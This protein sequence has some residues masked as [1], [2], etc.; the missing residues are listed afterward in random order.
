MKKAQ[1]GS[2]FSWASVAEIL[3]LQ[4]EEIEGKEEKEL[5]IKGERLRQIATGQISRGN[6]SGT[7]DENID[8]LVRFL[9]HPEI[10]FLS[11]EDLIEP[12][13]PYQ[14]AFQLMEF[15]KHDEHSDLAL[16]TRHLEGI[17]R[18]VVCSGGEISDI[19]LEIIISR[20]GHFVH[21]IEMADIFAH[22]EIKDPADWSPGERKR[23][24]DR[25][26]ESRGWGIL[27]PEDTLTGF[28]KR[29]SFNTY[30]GNHYSSTIASIPEFGA[31]V[32]EHLALLAYDEAYGQEYEKENR[33][34][35][36]EEIGQKVLSNNL[37]HFVRIP[38]DYPPLLGS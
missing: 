32:I 38:P 23:Y 15:L 22:A 11:L 33:Q 34:Q 19:R 31:G 30:R 10:R 2:S 13:L 4:M 37:R 14:F 5:R 1:F 36:F 27:T 28:M 3:H 25:Y 26:T 7:T 9:T 24:F 21:F 29:K 12:E 20:D 18:A 17:Y 6:P 16:P 8:L 35:W